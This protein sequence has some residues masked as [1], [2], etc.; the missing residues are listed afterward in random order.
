M[1]NIIIIFMLFPL[2]GGGGHRDIGGGDNNSLRV[3]G[4]RRT[5]PTCRGRKS[6]GY[7]NVPA[8]LCAGVG[9]EESDMP[10]EPKKPDVVPQADV[11]AEREIAQRAGNQQQPDPP[12]EKKDEQHD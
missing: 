4:L 11:A 12:Q 3:L 1:S 7:M 10:N 2:F 6:R 5:D 9:S 8:S